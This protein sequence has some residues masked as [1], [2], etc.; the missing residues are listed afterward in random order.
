VLRAGGG[1]LEVVEDTVVEGR[2]P[3]AH[4]HRARL[5]PPEHRVPRVGREWKLSSP[6]MTN[7]TCQEHVFMH[8]N[9]SVDSNGH[10]EHVKLDFHDSGA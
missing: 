5:L 8:G 2:L 6:N 7:K 9:V 4:V 10:L 3:R 1:R